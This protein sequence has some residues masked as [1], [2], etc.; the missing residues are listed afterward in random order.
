MDSKY[1]MKTEH[2]FLLLSDKLI[3]APLP[4][5]HHHHPQVLSFYLATHSQSFILIPIKFKLQHSNM[6]KGVPSAAQTVQRVHT[7][8]GC[9]RGLN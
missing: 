4:I 6:K 1:N 9:K 3:L 7:R 2:A 5:P 8:V